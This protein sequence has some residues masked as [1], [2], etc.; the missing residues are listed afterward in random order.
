[1]RLLLL[2][3]FSLFFLITIHIFGISLVY[4]APGINNQIHFQGKVVNKTT[5]TN[6]VDGSYPFVFKIYSVSSGGTAIWTESK[7]LTVANG[8]FQTY[9]GDTTALPASIDFNSDSLYLG[10]EYNTDGEMS[11]RV[12]FA[13]VPYAFNAA[14]VGG[15]TVTNTTGT[16]TI[17]NGKT[18]SFGDDFSTV[19]ANPLTF[20]TTGTTNVTLPTTGTLATLAGSETLTNKTIGS[21]G[22]TFAGGGPFDI[23]K[24]GSIAVS[25]TS[26]VLPSTTINTGGTL[27]ISGASGSSPSTSNGVIWYNQTSNKFEVVENGAIKVLC[28]TTDLGCGSGSTTLSSL[29]AA[30][31]TNTINNANFSQTWNW[32][33]LTTQ[34]GLA[35]NSSSLTSGS[36]LTAG[37]S[38]ASNVTGNLVSLSLSDTTGASSNTG[39][40]LAITNAGTANANTAVTIQ[41]NAQG[42]GNLAFR[43]NDEASDTTPTVIDGQG[44]LGVGTATPESLVQVGSASNRGDLNVYGQVTRKGYERQVNLT[45]IIDLFVY[46]TTQDADAGKWVDSPFNALLS[47]ATE[48]KDDG[49]N[50]PC[51]T[52]TDDRCGLSSF[53]RKAIIATTGGAL[54]IFDAKD[55][56]LWMKFTQSGGTFALGADT[57]NNPSGISA[58]N[59]VIYVGTNGASATGLY[60]FDFI[61]DRMY[62]YNTTDR[63]SAISGI[64]SRNSAVTY[65][66]DS[67][68][69]MAIVDNVVND[70][71]AAAIVGTNTAGGLTSTGGVSIVA[72][73]TNTGLSAINLN[74]R[75]TYDYSDVAGDDYTSVVITR[76]GRL[77]GMNKTQAQLERW[78]PVDADTTDQL[79]GTPDKL[80]DQASVP[81]LARTTFTVLDS[82]DSLE[83][84]DYGSYSENISDV[85]YAGTSLGLTELHDNVTTPLLGWVRYYNTA[86]QTDYMTGDV[87]GMFMFEEFSGSLTDSS[88]VGNFLE[89]EV[90]PTF[91]ADGVRGRALTFNGTSQHLCSD[92]NNDGTCDTDTDY[93]PAAL[94]FNISL[95]FKHST[96]ITGTDVLLDHTYNT[97][98]A[99]VGG[100]RIYMNSTGTISFGI[101]DDNAAFPEDVATSTQTYND[102]QWH[103]LT[104]VR[105]TGTNRI[106]LYIDGRLV[107]SD[108]ALSATGAL[109]VGAILS[110]G[111]DCSVG[112]A[113][114]TGANFWDGSIDDLR[115]SMGTNNF[116]T[117]DQVKQISTAGRVAAQRRT[118]NTTA[119]I[120][121]ATT[122]GNSGATWAPNEFVGTMV[123]ITLGTGI[124]QV[125]KVVS[126]TSTTLTV[127]PAWDVTPDGTSIFV[128]NHEGLY[129]SINAVTAVALEQYTPLTEIRRLFVGTGGVGDTGG[130]TVF[131]QTQHSMVS[132]VFNLNSGSVDNYGNA[133]GGVTGNN[134]KSISTNDNMVVYSHDEGFWSSVNGTDLEQLDSKINKYTSI[135]RGEFIRDTL[136]AYGLEMGSLGGADLAEYYRSKQQLSGGEIVILNGEAPDTVQ[137]SEQQY[138]L[139]VLGVVAS[140]PGF[141]LGQKS[142]DAYPV[143]LVGRVPVSVTTEA[144][145]VK[146]GDLITTSSTAGYG[147]K[148]TQAGVTIGIALE[149]LSEASMVECPTDRAVQT[150]TQ[151]GQVMVFVNLSQ[152]LGVPVESLLDS[153]TA[154][155][156]A[157]K[158][159]QPS[160]LEQASQE[161]QAILGY[162]RKQ[163]GERNE[164]A[165]R[166]ANALRVDRVQANRD[167]IAPMVITDLLLAKRVKAD[168][169][170]GF[171]LYTNKIDSLS[172]QLQNQITLTETSL[173]TL[174]AQLQQ[175]QAATHSS[176]AQL[177]NLF[178][179][180]DMVETEG[181]RVY[182]NA[183]F[184]GETAFQKLARFFGVVEFMQ[185]VKFLKKPLFAQDTVGQARIEQNATSVTVKFTE[186][187]KVPP[188]IN[189]SLSVDSTTLSEEEKLELNASLKSG[190]LQYYISSRESDQFKIQLTQPA[191]VRLD[192]SWTAW[193]VDEDSEVSTSLPTSPTPSASITPTPAPVV[194]ATAS[195][196]ITPPPP[197]TSSAELN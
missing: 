3:G 143:A 101:D 11:P 177:P 87:K 142:S 28:N 193:A 194:T 26:M 148:A 63:T 124:N 156:E 107:G 94:G 46:D 131:G 108:A 183:E 76:H 186:A 149:D 114:S 120:F 155:L 60:A 27:R 128:V 111:S 19:G 23:I 16:L 176:P 187:Y 78:N 88:R 115:I 166:S 49:P 163:L 34:T 14:K 126:N 24:S 80:W 1:M 161:Q 58:M 175:P 125:R 97:T 99:I 68:P 22:L 69:R 139:R 112:A 113:C 62:R 119:N 174:S 93:D 21:S 55:S 29:L 81:A 162:L 74:H 127:S 188:V 178:L 116:I 72:V 15:L 144:G 189:I 134:S 133:W 123:Q 182:N 195:T 153:T 140:Q 67:T 179:R 4:A 184:R 117:Q 64:G 147:M 105:Q 5:G 77:Y 54:Y 172:S 157:P 48:I 98:P 104:A 185:D 103:H 71:S 196:T 109:P 39:S 57:D 150:G 40:V 132:D 17:Q 165:T 106:D 164:V 53:P 47:W 154:S 50:D 159:Q 41:H 121:S 89:D 129:G 122:I 92:A 95:W 146:K 135:A 8:I 43:V 79:A 137:R 70:V 192:F 66:A 152:S 171:E 45:G 197:A 173:A 86:G 136:N 167:V 6:V 38:A 82:P 25:A 96:T 91:G 169:I 20:T 36:L 145:P 9:L 102:N 85:I 2:T 7:S 75:Q 30:T 31:A 61:N 180:S 84:I 44:R 73:A 190:A 141:I 42:T 160:V 56:S 18:V 12:R 118:V 168:T 83:V 13:A 10:V 35:L 51:N 130:T 110:V 181:L 191:P 138:D 59:G 37:S 100:F 158:T 32:N 151:C 65:S 170:E 90:A 33:S 52:A